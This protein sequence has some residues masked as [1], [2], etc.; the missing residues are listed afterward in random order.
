MRPSVCSATHILNCL[1][2]VALQLITIFFCFSC[3]WY[4]QR[5]YI[6]SFCL[7]CVRC[8]HVWDV[9][10]CEMFM[11]VRCLH[12]WDVYVCE[13]FMCVRCL[14]VW[15]VYVC[16]IFMCVRCSCVW[17][18]YVCE[19]FSPYLNNKFGINHSFHSFALVCISCRGTQSQL[20]RPVMVK[21]HRLGLLCIFFFPWIYPLLW[22]QNFHGGR[23]FKFVSMP[24]VVLFVVS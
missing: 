2:I 1:Y 17:D 24:G 19:M 14:C 22:P 4:Y 7:M 12:V 13:M 23:L 21:D 5:V 10:V 3:G 18:I 8:L 11:C 15:D 20:W 9:Y 16:E 6:Q